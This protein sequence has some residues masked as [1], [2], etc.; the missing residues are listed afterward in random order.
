MVE[1]KPFGHDAYC[2]GGTQCCLLVT[3][4][5]LHTL[6]ISAFKNKLLICLKAFTAETHYKRKVQLKKTLQGA[7]KCQQ[8]YPEVVIFFQGLNYLGTDF[9]VVCTNIQKV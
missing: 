6:L 1:W 2:C 4:I 3:L 8:M 9:P 5:T 7:N